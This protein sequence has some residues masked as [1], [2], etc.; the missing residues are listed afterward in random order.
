MLT[1]ILFLCA[2]VAPDPLRAATVRVGSG[3]TGVCV[4][5]EGYILTARHCLAANGSKPASSNVSVEFV[6]HG[7]ATAQVVH[8]ADKADVAVLRVPGTDWPFVEV[9]AAAPRE[10]DAV[11]SLGFPGGRFARHEGQVSFVGMRT[12]QT[13]GLL[14]NLRHSEQMQVIETDYRILPGSSGG[15][16]F[17]AGGAVLGL[18]SRST[19]DAANVPGSWWVHTADLHAA[20]QAAHVNVRSPAKDGPS[21]D[22]NPEPPVLYVLLS[23]KCSACAAFRRDFAANH[24]GLRETLQQGFA[25]QLV[26]YTEH[27]ELVE[28]YQVQAVPAFCSEGWPQAH[29]GYG[30]PSELLTALAPHLT[31]RGASKAGAKRDKAIP[32]A[33]LPVPDP[34]DDASLLTVVLLVRATE[35]SALTAGLLT[36]ADQY[37]EDRLPEAVAARL[38]GKVTIEIVFQ[39]L[40]PQRYAAVCTAGG[41]PDAATGAPSI[42]VLVLAE[43]RYTGLRGILLERLE[44]AFDSITDRRLGNVPMQFVFERTRPRDYAAVRAALLTADTVPEATAPVSISSFWS[45]LGALAGGSLSSLRNWARSRL[46]LLQA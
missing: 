3:C 40:H 2:L 18:A 30:T 15:P 34:T 29:E 19:T 45:I 46:T 14:R 35:S 22:G 43:Q 20:L 10:G 16:L 39:R 28:R 42:A 4:S 17:S 1:T 21:E 23:Q 9:A 12:F 11:T 38:S 27:P 41:V 31:V 13:P 37:L 26:D 24:G 32:D 5:P 33:V 25:V 6:S 8:V 7:S 44:L 36:T